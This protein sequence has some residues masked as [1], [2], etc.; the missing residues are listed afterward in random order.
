MIP[1][2]INILKLLSILGIVFSLYLMFLTMFLKSQ[3]KLVKKNKK[4]HSIKH[5][6]MLKTHSI[7]S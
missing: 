2:E 4:L 6:Y 7:Y 1:S 3:Q 5:V